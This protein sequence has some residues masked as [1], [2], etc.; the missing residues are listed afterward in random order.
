[1][2][3]V[4]NSLFQRLFP[5]PKDYQTRLVKDYESFAKLGR[6][7]KEDFTL[8]QEEL[9]DLA[10][11]LSCEQ[12]AG[13]RITALST[14]EKARLCVNLE[15]RYELN[16]GQ[17]SEVLALPEYLVKQILGSKDYGHPFRYTV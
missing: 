10:N 15:N 6:T 16:T 3:F 11:R 5:D 12:F 4:N 13:K 14:E 17:I 2:S 8:S 1:M 9:S 7:I